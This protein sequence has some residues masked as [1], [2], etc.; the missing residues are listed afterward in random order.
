MSMRRPRQRTSSRGGSSKTAGATVYF[1]S[2]INPKVSK[3]QACVVVE[4][5]AS[6]KRIGPVWGHSQA[7][8]RAALALLTE[9]CDCPAN[10]H[11]GDQYE[12][13]R[14]YQ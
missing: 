1:G 8:V 2:A 11:R 6:G 13:Y 4:C 14:L 9:A 7:S 3:K 12:G 10:Y 5:R